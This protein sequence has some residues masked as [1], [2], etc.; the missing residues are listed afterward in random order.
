MCGKRLVLP[1]T[2]NQGFLCN[3]VFISE[4]LK[5]KNEIFLSVSYDRNKEMPAITYSNR[6]GMIGGI[7]QIEAN[8]PETINRIFI[9][10]KEGLKMEDTYKVCLNL[11][12]ETVM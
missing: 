7:E 6:G 11:N 2:G 3:C 8:H 10:Y 9:D 4:R 12:I 1:S 5:V